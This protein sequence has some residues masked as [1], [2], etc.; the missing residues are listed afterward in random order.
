MD[1]LIL[2]KTSED[3]DDLE[4]NLESNDSETGFLCQTTK[5]FVVIAKSNYLAKDGTIKPALIA[6]SLGTIPD[7]WIAPKDDLK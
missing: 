7:I 6:R 3:F 1:I 2:G 4:K 5:E